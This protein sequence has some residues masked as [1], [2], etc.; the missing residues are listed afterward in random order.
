MKEANPSLTSRIKTTDVEAET[1]GV[2]MQKPNL[3]ADDE[4]SPSARS[5]FS[6]SGASGE[7]L[8]IGM[9]GS[10][11]TKTPMKTPAL[12]SCLPERLPVVNSRT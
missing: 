10:D 2:P 11:K 4:N 1:V 3:F 7:T 5:I 8:A 9:R 6:P 12:P